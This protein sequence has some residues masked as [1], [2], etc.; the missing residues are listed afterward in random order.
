M[1]EVSSLIAAPLW[2]Y[3]RQHHV[4][5]SEPQRQQQTRSALFGVS[6]MD[7][8]SF[9]MLC[10]LAAAQDQRS[11]DLND[12]L[13]RALR[14]LPL[15]ASLLLLGWTV[16]PQQ[17]YAQSIRWLLP[18]LIPAVTI[19]SRRL[20]DERIE[21]VAGLVEGAEDCAP[22]FSLLG[23]LW[24]ALPNLL[25][26]P[27]ALIDADV[28]ARRGHYVITPPPALRLP[29]RLLSPR[30]GVTRAWAVAAGL[31][32]QLGQAR[33]ELGK[34][35]ALTDGK[36]AAEQRLTAALDE[37]RRG[38][39]ALRAAAAQ[40]ATLA[41][42]TAREHAAAAAALRADLGSLRAQLAAAQAA[43]ASSEQA[44]T[45]ARTALQARITE[46][47]A[48]QTSGEAALAAAR[49]ERDQSAQDRESFER[50]AAETK[51]RLDKTLSQLSEVDA[52]RRLA[53]NTLVAATEESA[54]RAAALDDARA[55]LAA[56]TAAAD[57][58]TVANEAL[59]AEVEALRARIEAAELEAARLV[60]R[61]DAAQ[62]D[63]ARWEQ[64]VTL[65]LAD[66]RAEL[67]APVEQLQQLGRAAAEGAEDH[68]ALG[69]RLQRLAGE[70]RLRVSHLFD[71]ERIYT[72]RLALDEP[73]PIKAAQLIDE[74]TSVL[75][76]D[77]EARGNTLQMEATRGIQEMKLDAPKLRKA[78]HHLLLNAGARSQQSAIRLKLSR[79]RKPGTRFELRYQG[80]PLPLEQW[81]QTLARPDDPASSA[82]LPDAV[83]HAIARAMVEALGGALHIKDADGEQS[84]SFVLP[85]PNE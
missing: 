48:A 81:E 63:A 5:V 62:A 38:A 22:F 27:A 76:P 16:T 32:A 85:D 83:R 41:A 14:G 50:L 77:M 37:E 66:A 10:Q 15:G 6:R 78:L 67:R 70:L 60:A 57:A 4:D 75:A 54:Q 69:Q 20:D 35:R 17:L 52:Q 3:L 82:A 34:L 71:L 45:S 44:A 59:A 72:G 28:S 1:P 9:A 55:A 40:Q 79:D 12:A 33:A 74:L 84:L 25:Q 61:R 68:A 18:T 65:I 53:E 43:Q 80:E 46:L 2:G 21:V 42:D 24:G 49:A 36:A 64:L 73:Q 8:Q 47:E 30:D 31:H 19:T 58:A 23:H 51:T 13:E 11:G 7:W 56:A 39:A 29:R 26:L